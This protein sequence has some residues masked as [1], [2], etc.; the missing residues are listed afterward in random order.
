MDIYRDYFDYEDDTT[1]ERPDQLKIESE[2]T[3]PGGRRP[4]SGISWAPDGGTSIAIAYC[5]PEFLGMHTAS[6]CLKVKA[7]L[8]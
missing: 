5:S 8:F 2:F 3:D 7:L 6:I 4:V 1:S